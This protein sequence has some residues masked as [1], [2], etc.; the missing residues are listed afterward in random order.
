MAAEA[1]L[2]R[3]SSPSP[4]RGAS[5]LK[6]SKYAGLLNRFHENNTLSAFVAPAP[7]VVLPAASNRPGDS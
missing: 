4:A 2:R 7:L 3:P 6:V 1:R 5:R